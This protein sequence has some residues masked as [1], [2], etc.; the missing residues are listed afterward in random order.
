MWR[1]IVVVATIAGGVA[2]SLPPSEACDAYVECQVHHDEV[3]NRP[4]TDTNLYQPDGTCWESDELA[5]ACT[6]ACVEK[7]DR[8]ARALEEAGELPGPCAQ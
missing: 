6:D 2:C 7:N 1:L 4:E 5:D 8:L 3:L